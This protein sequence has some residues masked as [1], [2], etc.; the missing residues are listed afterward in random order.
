MAPR[1]RRPLIASLWAL[2][3]LRVASAQ[4][5]LEP[6]LVKL[7]HDKCFFDMIV[8][9]LA[10]RGLLLAH[11]VVNKQAEMRSF[12]D[13]IQNNPSLFTTIVTP[14]GEGMSVSY[15][16]QSTLHK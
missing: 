1:T 10:P 14:S 8:P 6:P 16:L 11:N 12:L 4:S 13:A 3:F 2:A 9:R 7:L 15:K 5:T